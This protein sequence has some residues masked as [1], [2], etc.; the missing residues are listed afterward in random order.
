MGSEGFI[1]PD[2]PAPP[3]V[4][5]VVTTRTL[6]GESK[7]PFDR[8]NLGL[9]GGDDPAAVI[10]NR[11]ALERA[12]D[13]P[14]APRWMQQVHGIDVY[15]A[16]AVLAEIEPQADA[17]VTRNADRVLAV[18]TADCLPVFLS[19]DDGTAVGLAHAG[20]RGLAAGVVEATVGK[21]AR[22]PSSLIAW[23]GPSIGARSYEVGEEVRDA[24]VDA[25]AGAC[26]AFEPTRPGHWLCDLAALARRRLAAA[27]V[28]RVSGGGFDTFSD[29]R[30][31]SYR[32]D[33]QT[34]RFA[35]LIW[36][37]PATVKVSDRTPSET[38]ETP[39]PAQPVFAFSR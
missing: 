36:L 7:P 26:T 15:D 23:L 18:L 1:V 11:A 8:F 27:G 4:R 10:A 30:F 35:S 5:A 29:P 14:E 2:W 31:Y 3:N 37:A 28:G 17:A 24:F 38:V 39:A 13:L 33:R 20:W 16:D 19:A 12:L 6:P 9:R 32:R 34:G 21:L 22:P 25:D